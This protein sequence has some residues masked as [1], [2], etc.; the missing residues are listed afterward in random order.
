MFKSLEVNAINVRADFPRSVELAARYGFQGVHLDLDEVATLGI[1]RA[2]EILDRAG[3][4]PS[5][6]RFPIDYTQPEPRFKAKLDR[7]PAQCEVA[8]ALGITRTAYWIRPFHDEMDFDRN[9]AFH[10]DRLGRLGTVMKQY[11]IRMG[12]EF[13]GPKTLLPGHPYTFIRTMDG[14]LKLCREIG[15]GNMGLLLDAYHLYTSHGSI[16]DVERLTDA[17]IVEVHVNDAPAGIPVDEQ[18]DLVRALPGETG[19]I[20]LVGFLKALARV[21][22]S[23]PVMV[24]PFSERVNA[25]APDDAVRTTAEALDK[26]WKQAGLSN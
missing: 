13:I 4:R 22:Y 18:L 8:Q 12:L 23:G 14:M 24:E 17:D 19:V 10:L 1:A 6:F 2:K 16:A 15:T 20:D 21:G 5:A 7:F 9:Y 26:V 3:I 25:M 11:G